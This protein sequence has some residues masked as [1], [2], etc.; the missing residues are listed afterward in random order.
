MITDKLD[1]NQ[2]KVYELI[3]NTTKNIFGGTLEETALITLIKD[4]D[5]VY[6]K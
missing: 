2:M 4:I 5:K 6:A 3:N 1:E